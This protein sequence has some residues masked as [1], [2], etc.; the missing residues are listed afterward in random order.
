[1]PVEQSLAAGGD[2]AERTHGWAGRWV[3]ICDGVVL[4]DF[5]NSLGLFYLQQGDEFVIS[6]SLAVLHRLYPN[7]RLVPRRF[8]RRGMN[9]WPPP[10]TRME[11]V[12]KLL[13]DQT[14]DLRARAVRYAPKCRLVPG[15]PLD[16]PTVGA[17]LLDALQRVWK[18]LAREFQ[19]IQLTLTG[20]F[21]SRTLMAAGLSAGVRFDAVTLEHGRISLADRSLPVEICA[22]SS[23]PHRYVRLGKR[24]PELERLYD[25]HTLRDTQEADRDYWRRN[26]FY[27]LEEGDCLMRGA[28]FAL[29]RRHFH[30][31]FRGLSWEE[32]TRN[33]ARL[34][35]PFGDFTSVR[36]EAAQISEWIQWRSQHP[37][38]HDWIDAFYRD[39][40]LCGWAAASEQGLDL[41]LGT[42]INPANCGYILDLLQRAPTSA[43]SGAAHQIECIRQSGTGLERFPCNPVLEGPLSRLTMRLRQIVSRAASEGA[44]LVRI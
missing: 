1:V 3:V 23:V 16:T 40:R 35:R 5:C 44:N 8:N 26:M 31:L 41:L 2:L 6:S 19:R 32:V 4:G 39:Q 28:A 21:D 15:P 43:K 30:P 29:A 20:G 24:R 11:G 42:S 34:V 38:P 18:H 25:E 33:P 14:I 37:G 12:R 7:R 27:W 9:W 22:H 36:L 13:P 17:L 10:T